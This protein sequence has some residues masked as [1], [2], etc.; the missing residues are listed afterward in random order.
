MILMF[1]GLKC[2]HNEYVGKLVTSSVTHTSPG[3]LSSTTLPT[4]SA[5]SFSIVSAICVSSAASRSCAFGFIVVG[6]SCDGSST[7]GV[8][9]PEGAGE[10]LPLAAIEWVPVPPKVF[11]TPPYLCN[12][13][14]AVDAGPAAVEVDGWPGVVVDVAVDEDSW[15]TTRSSKEFGFDLMMF[16]YMGS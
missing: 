5:C 10:A 3:R 14:A 9:A 8:A 13:A 1:F 4:A 15:F 12:Q 6:S 16:S 2:D 11:A 7:L